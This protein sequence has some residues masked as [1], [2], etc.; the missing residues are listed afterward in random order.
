M[1][2]ARRTW[3]VRRSV[4][5]ALQRRR[6][7]FFSSLPKTK[8]PHP[9]STDRGAKLH[10]SER[11]DGDWDMRAAPPRGGITT[12]RRLSRFP[13]LRLGL[14]S[15]PSHPAVGGTVACADFNAA[16]SCGAAMALLRRPRGTRA[17]SLTIFPHGSPNGDHSASPIH[18]SESTSSNAKLSVGRFVVEP[19]GE[20]KRFVEEARPPKAM[21][22]PQRD[23]LIVA[24]FRVEKS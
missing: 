10:Q 21:R 24:R 5:R 7:A 3:R 22:A 8:R 11:R 15:A 14:L 9:H 4:A 17:R 23:A 18:L 1:R 16:H 2:G 13:G 19:Q 12:P 20:V 6:W